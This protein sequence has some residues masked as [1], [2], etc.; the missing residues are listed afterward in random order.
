MRPRSSCNLRGDTQGV[1]ALTD[2]RLLVALSLR[3]HRD[4]LKGIGPGAELPVGRFHL[5]AGAA[6]KVDA[7][8]GVLKRQKTP[9]IISILF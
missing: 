5:L 3:P 6:G 9:S 7:A 4:Q 1:R 8:N 2:E